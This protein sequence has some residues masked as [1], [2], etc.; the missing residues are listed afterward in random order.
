MSYGDELT[1]EERLIGT[2]DWD[3]DRRIAAMATALN[4][5]HRALHPTGPIKSLK[6][7]LFAAE[8]FVRETSDRDL[9]PLTRAGLVVREAL[10]NEAAYRV[11]NY[12]DEGSDFYENEGYEDFS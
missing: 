3:K 1:V 2:I 12:P 6:D 9:Q 11:E 7:R 10:A 8:G 4:I 5:A